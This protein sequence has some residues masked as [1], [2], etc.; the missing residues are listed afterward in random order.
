MLGKLVNISIFLVH[1]DATSLVFNDNTFDGYWSVQTLQ[2]IPD[3]KKANKGSVIKL[4]SRIHNYI[5]DF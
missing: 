5:N 3:L 2:H 1:G 4:I